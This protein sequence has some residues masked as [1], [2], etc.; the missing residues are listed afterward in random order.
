MARPGLYGAASLTL[1]PSPSLSD[2]LHTLAPSHTNTHGSLA[3]EGYRLNA[4]VNAR[5]PT[6]FTD[7]GDDDESLYYGTDVSGGSCRKFM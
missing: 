2:I 7:Y 1:S 4:G 6:Q 5:G 3:A